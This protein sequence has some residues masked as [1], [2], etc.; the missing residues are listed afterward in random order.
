VNPHLEY[1]DHLDQ[2]QY[3]TFNMA[4]K[5]TVINDFAELCGLQPFSRNGIVWIY[6]DPAKSPNPRQPYV[7]VYF[8]AASVLDNTGNIVC[9][10]YGI[11]TLD[12][13]EFEAGFKNPTSE[14]YSK[15]EHRTLGL[16]KLKPIEIH[17]ESINVDYTDLASVKRLFTMW[18]KVIN[19][20]WVGKLIDPGIKGI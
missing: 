6:N 19:Y 7:T 18:S 11:D 9:N 12:A 14:W 5:M 15:S 4:Q 8:N 3:S 1:L 10:S 13:I 17:Q 2:H 20:D 16:P